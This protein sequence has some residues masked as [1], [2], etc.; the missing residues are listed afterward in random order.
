LRRTPFPAAAIMSDVPSNN[1]WRRGLGG[2]GGQR[3][4]CAPR[5]PRRRTVV[6]KRS[7]HRR[8][9]IFMPLE[10]R[11]LDR[12][13]SPVPGR[14]SARRPSRAGLC[15]SPAVT[16]RCR[17]RISAG[18]VSRNLRMNVRCAGRGP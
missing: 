5:C 11:I 7:P 6:A 1:G 12:P 17:T 3:R 16:M 2:K 10:G 18:S 8:R 4:G 14:P 15:S 13:S 9:A